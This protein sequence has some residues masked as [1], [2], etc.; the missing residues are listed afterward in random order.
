M[1]AYIYPYMKGSKSVKAL[2]EAMDAKRIKLQGSRFRP[3]SNKVVINWGS[4]SIPDYDGCTVINQ[5]IKSASNKRQAFEVLEDAGVSIP[6]FTTDYYEAVNW[7]QDGCKVVCRTKLS[8]HSGDGIVIAETEDELVDAP[9]YTKYIPKKDEYRAH[10]IGG[11]VV[12]IQRKMRKRD[13]PDD[14]VN[15]KVRNHCNGFIFG[16]EGVEVSDVC[17]SEAIISVDAL[18][19]DF[20]AVDL[21]YNEYRDKYYVLEVNTAVGLTGTTLEVY[22]EKLNELIIEL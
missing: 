5:H 14:E 7:L 13:I 17:K 19:L 1:K 4:S 3:T 16:R 8:G 11:E 18:G 6:E 22:A 9:L 21:I 15:W 10:V 12:D 20:G 2:A